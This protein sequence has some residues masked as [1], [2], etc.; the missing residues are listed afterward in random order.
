MSDEITAMADEIRRL[1]AENARLHADVNI[2]LDA[3]FEIRFQFDLRNAKLTAAEAENASLRKA[4][5]AVETYFDET[6]A[7]S[8]HFL[9]F[10]K[11]LLVTVREALNGGPCL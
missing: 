9:P 6:T 11:G 8:T 4:L 5:E 7:G 2:Q 3:L 1:E 10:E